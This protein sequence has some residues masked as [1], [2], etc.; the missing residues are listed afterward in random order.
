MPG[1]STVVA[2]EAAPTPAIPEATGGQVF[3]LAEVAGPSH[4]LLPDPNRGLG[5]KAGDDKSLADAIN[6]FVEGEICEYNP[7]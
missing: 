7:I 4:G 1:T 6:A 5:Q 2:V 3:D